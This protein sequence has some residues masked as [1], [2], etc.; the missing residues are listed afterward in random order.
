[1]ENFILNNGVSIPAI[2]LGTWDNRDYNSIVETLKSAFKMGYRHIDTAG[3]YANEH[4]IGRAVK[5]AG[6]RRE[7]L[8]ITSKVWASERGYIKTMK[9]FEKTIADLQ[10]DY[11]DLYLIHWPASP[12]RYADWDLINAE[13]W[14]ALEDLHKAGKI[15]AIG[16]S[17]FWVHLLEPLL[18]VANVRPMVNQIEY[19]PGYKQQEVV[20]F[21]KSNNILVEAW[22]PL[23]RGKMFSVDL[24]AQMAQKY[25]VNIA[26]IC[27][28][29]CLQNGVL[30]L[31]KSAKPER[32]K[33]NIEID[34]FEISTSDMAQINALDLGSS[35]GEYPDEVGF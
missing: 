17:N 28:K 30:P 12:K 6:I 23:G 27:I 9:A 11:L 2:G 21:C 35:S 4:L 34:G 31:P 20:D 22:S 25:N 33:Q 24:L 7:D 18:K 15:R 14:H 10:T 3:F 29:W 16:M 5:D 19:H 8:F 13:T 1:M 32:L 26:Q